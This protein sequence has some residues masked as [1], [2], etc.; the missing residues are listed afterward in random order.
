MFNVVVCCSAQFLQIS[1]VTVHP[2]LHQ[3]W[4]GSQSEKVDA[5]SMKNLLL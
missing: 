1:T 2:R 3:S 5:A 4:V